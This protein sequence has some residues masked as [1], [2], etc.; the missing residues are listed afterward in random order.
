MPPLIQKLLSL[1]VPV[2]QT[3]EKVVDLIAASKDPQ[4][5][6]DKVL[7][8]A[9]QALGHQTMQQAVNARAKLP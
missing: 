9:Y 2:V 6:A 5:A 8:A 7:T 4:E 3:I 1:A